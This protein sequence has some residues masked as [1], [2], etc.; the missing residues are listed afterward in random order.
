MTHVR[1]GGSLRILVVE[2]GGV[3]S[4]Y[5]LWVEPLGFLDKLGLGCE[6]NE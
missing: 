4:D 5:I 3:N 6:K 1:E 2:C